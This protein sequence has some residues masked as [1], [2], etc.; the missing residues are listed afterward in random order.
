MFS[1]LSNKLSG[2]FSQLKKRGAL[3]GADIDAAMREVRVALLEADVALPVARDFIAS[4]KEKALGA[5]V[6][7]SVTPAQMVVKLTSDHLTEL[8]GSEN[9]PINLA[10][11]PPVVI[12]MLG[13]QGSGKTTSTGKL[14]LRLKTKQHKKILVASLDV[15]RPAA[16]A[17]LEQVA[18]QSGIASL[19]VVAGEK[20]LQITERALKAARLEGYDVLLLDTAGRLHI[21]AELMDELKSVK[22]LANPLETF[23]V[24]DSLTGQD[25]VNIAKAFHD[26]I[27]VTGIILTRVDGDGRG[28][29]ALSM[30]AVT[31]QPIKFIG[32][33][34]RPEEFEEFHPA[35]I[36]SRILDMGDIVSLVEKA[37]ENVTQAEA[38]QMA[39]RMMEG[40]F[41]FNDLLGQLQKMH[42]MGG[43]GSM[44]NL[45]PG[46]GQIKEKLA[47]ATFDEK[48]LSRQEAIILSMTAQERRFPK[49]INGSRRARIAAGAGAQVQD[50]NK[51]LR[52][53]QQMQDL[54]KKLK[55]M[56]K[57]GLMRG[58][59]G[60]LAGLTGLK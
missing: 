11:A 6:V 36:A 37:A 59:M 25:A 4:L 54:M 26:Q 12:M 52:Q 56:G 5:E 8:L 60:G 19:P 41:D 3:T 42:K 50:V 49:V 51:L 40:Q 39:A 20:P 45:L 55:K 47:G 23:L 34:E 43:I 18:K 2:I 28:G 53:Q 33:G 30:R 15:Y 32:T 21:D 44:M 31:G 1:S 48:A 9:Q 17:Q 46:M 27:G 38:E 7:K 22:Q 24:A 14:A 58:G 16:Q 29:A 35:R 57:K 10:A 13:L